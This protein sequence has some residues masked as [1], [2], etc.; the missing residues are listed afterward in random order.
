MSDPVSEKV[1][2]AIRA[3]VAKHSGSDEIFK[4]ICK[5]KGFEVSYDAEG[6]VTLIRIRKE[7]SLHSETQ[8]LL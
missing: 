6:V 8:K 1:L 4:A 7:R 3:E 2:T 5:K